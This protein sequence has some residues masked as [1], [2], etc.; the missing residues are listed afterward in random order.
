MTQY[1]ACFFSSFLFY[2][3]RAIPATYGGSQAKGQIGATAA[4]V[5]TATATQDLIYVCNLHHSSRQCQIPNSLSQVRD[6]TQN[7]R[8]T[9]QIRF[10]CATMGPPTYISLSGKSGHTQEN[11]YC[12]PFFGGGAACPGLES[13]TSITGSALWAS[14]L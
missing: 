3:F 14:N 9:I 1:F 2:F 11:H 4:G 7:L 10:R 5:A 8:V 13:F 6:R 12:N